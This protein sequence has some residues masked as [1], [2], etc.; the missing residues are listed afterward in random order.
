MALSVLKSLG[1]SF[2]KLNPVAAIFWHPT[3]NGGLTPE[4]VAP[5]SNRIVW[6]HCPKGHEWKARVEHLTRGL[7]C[8]YCSGHRVCSDNNFALLMP[9]VARKWHPTLNGTLTP[10]DVRPG[11]DKKAWW[12]CD[13]GHVWKARVANMAKQLGVGC[14]V[15]QVEALPERNRKIGVRRSGTLA[16]CF[17]ELVAEC[18]PMHNGKWTPYDVSPKSGK[19]VWWIC[20]RGHEWTTRVIERTRYGTDCPECNPHTSKLEIRLLCELRALFPV[21]EWRRRI[22][23]CECDMFIPDYKLVIE[24]DGYPWHD[25]KESRD[26]AKNAVLNQRGMTVLRIRDDRLGKIDDTDIQFSSHAKSVE[27][28]TAVVSQ[29]LQLLPLKAGTY[30]LCNDYVRKA[31]LVGDEEYK[32]LIALLPGPPQE[33]SLATLRPDISGQWHPEKN[34]PLKPIM[35]SLGSNKNIWWVC[36][37]GHEWR[38]SIVARTRGRGCPICSRRLKGDT[39]RKLSVVR[40]GSLAEKNPSLA[41]EWHPVKN[42]PLK[43][44]DRSAGSHDEVWWLCNSGHEWKDNIASR[45][46]GVGCPFCA[47]RKPKRRAND[48]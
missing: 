7:G 22:E 43:P 5:K 40:N 46:R 48:I 32:R 41:K 9:D 44:S 42:G 6:C 15:C 38:A 21:V 33:D 20:R 31:C 24:L 11:S 19:R 28:A 10:F 27:I 3:R 34:G 26:M 4:K 29:L 47:G 23:G 18:H 37:E 2:A 1:G 39:Y 45:N 30:S 25:K 14:R 16:D 8:P 36:A 17:P 12:I 35:F 13:K